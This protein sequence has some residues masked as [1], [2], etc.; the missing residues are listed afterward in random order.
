MAGG[1]FV[2]VSGTFA[3]VMYLAIGIASIIVRGDHLSP[4]CGDP[5]YPPLRDW[6]LGT[7]ISYTIIGVAFFLWWFESL[8]G[9]L[10]WVLNVSG[11]WLFI[12]SVVGSVSLWR[13]GGNCQALNFPLWQMGMGAVITSWIM[14]A[15]FSISVKYSNEDV[16]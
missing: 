9:L 7:G 15:F 12:W 6:L 14:F 11:V 3:A 5:G 13:D 10:L 4:S 1:T 8:H 16:N 2:K